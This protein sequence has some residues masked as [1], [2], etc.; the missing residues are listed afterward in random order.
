MRKHCSAQVSVNDTEINE[1]YK[2]N[3]KQFTTEEQRSAR[4]ILIAASEK[5]APADKEKARQKRR[6]C[7][8]RSAKIR[9]C[10][11]AGKRKL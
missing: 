7:W 1:F 2:A 4:H 11:K 3:A 9:I 8:N 6:L 10:C 5:A